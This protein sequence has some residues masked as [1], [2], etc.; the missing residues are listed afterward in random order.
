M[1][2]DYE[3]AARVDDGGSSRAFR[4]EKRVDDSV[5]KEPERAYY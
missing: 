5:G 3:E 4:V 2:L 1:K